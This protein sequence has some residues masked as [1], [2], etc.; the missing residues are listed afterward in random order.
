MVGTGYPW[1]AT[2]LKFLVQER[3]RY[4]P[5]AANPKYEDVEFEPDWQVVGIAVQIYRQPP[6]LRTYYDLLS[7]ADRLNDEWDQVAR[8]AAA[9]GITPEIVKDLIEV[10]G[11]FVRQ[12]RRER[13][14]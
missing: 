13:S 2:E 9:Y 5:R 12:A 7:V 11:R 4:V 1:T 8:L 14:F 10:H 6:A 3:G